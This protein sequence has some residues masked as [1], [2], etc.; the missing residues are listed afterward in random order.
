MDRLKERSNNNGDADNGEGEG[1][2]EEPCNYKA[3]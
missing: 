1:G 2:V 3:Q